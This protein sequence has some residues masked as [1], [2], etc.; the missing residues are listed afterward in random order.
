MRQENKFKVICGLPFPIEQPDLLCHLHLFLMAKQYQ[1]FPDAI[2]VNGEPCVYTGLGRFEH[3]K[4]ISQILFKKSFEWHSWSDLVVRNGCEHEWLF[5]SGCGA[6]SKSTS[7]GLY[8]LIWW[9]SNPMDSAVIIAS[10]TIE[11]AK[12]RIWREVARFYSL[13]S[14]LIGGYKDAVIGSS[15]RPSICPVT[16][17]DRKKDEAHGL[18]VTALHGKE[19]DK[20]IGYIKGFHPKRILVIADELDV[21]EDGGKALIDTYTDNL[22]TGTWESQ[23][24]GLGNDPSLLNALGDM[25]Q[26]ELGKPVTLENTEWIS[27]KDVH[28]LRLDAWD[29]PNIRDNNKWTGLVRQKDIDDLIKRKGE[30]SPSVYIQLHGIHPPEGADN[31]VLSEATLIRYHCFDPV[32]WKGDFIT[33]AALDPGFGDDPCVLRFFQRGLDSNNKFRISVG[34]PIEITFPVEDADYQIAFQTIQ[35]CK[36]NHVLPDEFSILSTG[37]GRGVA[38]ILR[39]EWSQRIVE[40]SEAGSPSDRIISEEYPVPANEEYDRK[41]TELWFQIRHFV[42]ADLLRSLDKKTAAQLCSRRYD[43]KGIG[44]NKRKISIQKK[45]EMLHSPNDADA[46]AC[47]IEALV[48]KGIMPTVS[49][50]SKEKSS[51]DFQKLLEE[52]DFDASEFAYSNPLLDDLQFGESY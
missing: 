24:I 52:M 37:V 21:L 13:F 25:M 26:P 33:S 1:E 11:S 15:P 46:L 6:S 51:T 40:V 47:G 44:T 10:K 27:V 39:R 22:R 5:I 48:L 31:T 8:S 36:D 30:N 16:G 43:D 42:E 7:I 35:K 32:T 12:K 14:S 9:M 2:K 38:A 19:L 41:V 49:T 50:E 17:H 28:C 4:V 23:F 45:E 3:A 18:F 20:E 34:P 29:S